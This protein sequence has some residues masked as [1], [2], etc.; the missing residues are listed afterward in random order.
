M[1]QNLR[2]DQRRSSA[3]AVFDEEF[4]DFSYLEFWQLVDRFSLGFKE[5]E[6]VF[7]LADNSLSTLAAY[8]AAHIRNTVPLLLSSSI[9]TENL[10]KLLNIYNPRF[11]LISKSSNFQNSN[12]Q[13]KSTFLDLNLFEN[14]GTSP[15]DLSELALLMTTS[16]STGNPKLIRLSKMNLESNAESITE[17]LKMDST[18]RAITTLPF[19]YSYGLSII[20][21]HLYA[22]GSLIMNRSSITERGFWKNF[23][24]FHPTQLGGVPYTYEMLQR[25]RGK[26]FKPSSLKTLTQAGGRMNSD[27]A[28]EFADYCEVND[29]NFFVM[30]GQTE[31]TARISYITGKE[32]VDHPTSIGKPIPGGKLRILDED[33]N[34][35]SAQIGELVY[36][37]PNV[38]MGYAESRSD[39]NLP[40]VNMGILRTGDLGYRDSEGNFYITGRKSRLAK[41][42]GVRINLDDLERIG[43]DSNESYA[44]IS[45]EDKIAVYYTKSTNSF[46]LQP[47]LA[48]RAGINISGIVMKSIEALP[49]TES[50]KIDYKT[51]NEIYYQ[52]AT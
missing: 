26:L 13:W 44:C 28:L 15:I 3:P 37:G 11:V 47:V 22:G 21:T 38:S 25:M 31:A 52:N 29:V 1:F 27:L 24:K 40:D 4:G 19:N 18:S 43:G 51:L 14:L 9:K 35:G 33:Q 20:H 42:F 41:V 45:V 46:E 23:E 7:L 34:D 49:R 30:Y 32:L 39:L 16:G 17:Y 8:C 50:G 10:L 48:D 6:L 5:R 12:Y 36:E 2:D